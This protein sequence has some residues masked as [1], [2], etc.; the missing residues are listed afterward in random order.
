MLINQLFRGVPIVVEA[1]GRHRRLELL[2]PGFAVGN[3]GLEFG[4]PLLEC[5]ERTLLLLAL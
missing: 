1:R 2:D 3:P 4:N 5:F